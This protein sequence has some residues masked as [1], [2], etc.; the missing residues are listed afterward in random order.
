[1]VV[2]YL[3]GEGDELGLRWRRWEVCDSHQVMGHFR[4]QRAGRRPL[5]A[6]PSLAAGAA[7]AWRWMEVSGEPGLNL[8]PHSLPALTRSGASHTAN[9]YSPLDSCS[10]RCWYTS[11]HFG[12]AGVRCHTPGL[13]WK[14][15]KDR[16][17][18]WEFNTQTRVWVTLYLKCVLVHEGDSLLISSHYQTSQQRL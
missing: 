12:S 13:R 11:H 2:D 1:M 6:E 18:V 4:A 9:P 15:C 3:K 8:G 7:T 16:K 5:S 17:D 10:G 14:Q